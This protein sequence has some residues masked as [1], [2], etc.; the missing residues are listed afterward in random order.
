MATIGCNILSHLLLVFLGISPYFV[1]YFTRFTMP[2]LRCLKYFV[3]EDLTVY[4][5]TSISIR[6]YSNFII[7][8]LLDLISIFYFIEFMSVNRSFIWIYFQIG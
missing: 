4:I 3:N 7:N 8:L 5:L 6:S 1:H 2:F